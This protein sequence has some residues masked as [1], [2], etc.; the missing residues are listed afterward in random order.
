MKNIFFVI[1]WSRLVTIQNPDKK[2]RFWNGQP[3]CFGLNFVLASQKPD[4]I[5]WLA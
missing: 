2:I 3:S 1:K 4:W 5:F